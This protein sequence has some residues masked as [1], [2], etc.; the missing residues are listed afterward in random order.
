MSP[1]FSVRVTTQ[2]PTHMDSDEQSGRTSSRLM[3]GTG[4]LLE[5][6]IA[7]VLE[8]RGRVN[9]GGHWVVGWSA[10]G[11]GRGRELPATGCA[12]T[13]H[14]DD[15]DD[16]NVLIDADADADASSPHT[17]H[18]AAHPFTLSYLTC[19]AQPPPDYTIAANAPPRRHQIGRA[20]V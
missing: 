4:M 16:E 19:L 1:L 11:W 2:W 5:A 9:G 6:W 7:A 13:K 20:H 14:N 18:A 3:Q 12:I 10:G 15:D 8:I 17:E